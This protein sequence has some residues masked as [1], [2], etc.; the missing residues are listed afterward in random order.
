ME[1]KIN[2]IHFINIISSLH[3]KYFPLIK[4]KINVR[5]LFKPWLTS[6]ILNSIKKKNNLYR[7]YIK[8]KSPTLKTNYI[9]Y[10]NKL[11]SIRLAEKQYYVSK[12]V[13]VKDNISKTWKIMNQ[14][15]GRN[16][17]HKQIKEINDNDVTIDG[18][19]S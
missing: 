15:C 3:N 16:S 11:V 18:Q 8:T 7:N 13:E 10:K 2:S 17:M 6:S 9:E 19:C 4:T 12:L 5:S 1:L 14:M